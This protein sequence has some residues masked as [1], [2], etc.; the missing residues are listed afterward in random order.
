VGF[1]RWFFKGFFWVGFYGWV[2]YWQPC[3]LA[4]GLRR[5]VGRRSAHPHQ[6]RLLP[7]SNVLPVGIREGFIVPITSVVDRHRFDADP[8]PNFHYDADPDPDPDWHQ[9]NAVTPKV[10]F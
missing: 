1:F 9:N 10:K 4:H 6:Q 7:S 8:D 3:H 2:F 5:L